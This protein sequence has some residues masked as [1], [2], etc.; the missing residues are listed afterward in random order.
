MKKKRA[1]SES[2]PGVAPCPLRQV[3]TALAALLGSLLAFS[4]GLAAEAPA[5]YPVKPVRMI[6][7]YAAGGSVDAVA[8]LL[9]QKMTQAW[10]QQI[11]VDNRPGAGSIIGTQVAAI[12]P[13]DGYTLVIFNTSNAVT[14][15]VRRDLPYALTKDFVG[16]TNLATMT[17][18]LVVSPSL[19]ATTAREFIDL[20]RSKPGELNYGSGG[21]GGITHLAGEWFNLLAGTRLVHVPYK[22]GTFAV[23]DVI[24]GK[25]EMML[26]NMLSAAP[27]LNSRKLRGLAVTSLRRSAF[28]PQLPALTEAGLA[29]Y[30]LNEW[31]GLAVP[32][33]TP[34]A[35][36]ARLAAEAVRLFGTD[37]VR[38]RL[39]GQ[40]T[41]VTLSSPVQF[42]Q[43]LGSEVEKYRQIAAQADIRSD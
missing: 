42:R 6:V 29:G 30:D 20:A 25:V 2:A 21:S 9:A 34:G 32:A 16:V 14:A 1:S 33:G 31:N 8:R 5:S 39:A 26:L 19:A 3:T 15:A 10:G 11:V 40:G 43:M 4:R 41:E 22:G 18:V 13:P 24:A 36:V 7:P 23:L 12:A 35:T 38:Q 37:D 17:D 28:L 27:Q